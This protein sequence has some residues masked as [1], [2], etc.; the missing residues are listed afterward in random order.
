MRLLMICTISSLLFLIPA[1]AAAQPYQYYPLTPC[2]VVDTRNA[3]GV[4]GGPALT[5]GYPTRDFAIRG[6]CGVPSAARAVSVNLAIVSP[7]ANS[8]LELWPSGL[9]RPFTAT[10]NFAATD[11]ALSNGAIVPLSTN[12]QD[13]TVLNASGNVHLVI[14]VTGYFQ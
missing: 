13:L 14:D 6:Y 3:N 8:W 9:T 7:T 11:A 2:R 10:I 1:S 12:T 4:D 5:P